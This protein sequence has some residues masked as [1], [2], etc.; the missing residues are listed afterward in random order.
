MFFWLSIEI[1]GSL[2]G[3]EF[4]LDDAMLWFAVGHH[5]PDWITF[6][7]FESPCN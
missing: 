6:E 7:A 3:L 1:V 2:V 4:R 5:I